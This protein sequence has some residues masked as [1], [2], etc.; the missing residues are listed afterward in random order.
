MTALPNTLEDAIVQAQDATKAAITA[1]YTRLSVE[2]LFPELKVMP[3]AQT[4][5]EAFSEFGEGIKVFFTDAGTA[6]WAKR[7]WGDVPYQ[8][9][10]IDVAGSRQTTTVQ[11]QVAS[12]DKLYLVVSPT[13]VEVNPLEEICNAAPGVPVI[14]LN[15]RL[16]DISIVGIGY[17]GRMLRE[18]FLN[19][20]E[21][22]YYLRPLDDQTALTRFYPTPWQVWLEQEG[23]WQAIAEEREKPDSE[24][25]EA[26]LN[27]ATGS[28]R[29]KMGWAAELQQFLKA[30]GR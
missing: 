26:I 12:E 15:P 30:L 19:T 8:F 2:F 7:N 28:T 23:T 1:G 3:I 11:E 10:S 6:A 18:R 17:A 27:S 29:K 25:L 24:Q 20:I 4:F 13:S 14:L 5:V 16:E 21:P 22:C 9:R